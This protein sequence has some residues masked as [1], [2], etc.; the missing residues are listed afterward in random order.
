MYIS[1]NSK[2]I[3]SIIVALIWTT[4]ALYLAGPWIN[5][6]SQ[7]IGSFLAHFVIYGIAIFPGFMNAFLISSLLL[8]KRPK[9]KEHINY[10]PLTI[11]I[12]AYNEE[13]TICDTIHS[14]LL[15]EYTN[16]FKIIVLDDGSTDDT[17]RRVRREYSG[18]KKVVIYENIDNI[19]K[20]NLLNIGLSMVETDIFITIDSDSYLYHDSLKHLVG[21]Y[22]SDPTSAAIVGA[23]LVRN[24]RENVVTRL[25]E[26]D[27]F[28]GIAAIK[29]IQSLYQGTLVAQGAYS[30]YETDK[31]R[32]VDGW[33]DTV[34]EDI[35]LTWDLLERGYRI[36]YAE[37]ACLFTNAPNTWKQFFKQRSRWSRGIIE[38]FKNNW[39][40]LFRARKTTLFI[41]WNLLFVYMDLVY[42]FA[43]IPGIILAFFGIYSIVGPMTLLVL[44]LAMIVNF[45]MFF[46]SN[47]M[48]REQ[49]LKVRGNLLG[50][51]LYSLVYSVIL[52]PASTFGYIKELLFPNNKNWGTK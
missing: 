33:R 27:Y 2:Y 21:R 20:A 25:Q 35:V 46:R 18:N 37:N 28:H 26:W 9:I 48:F 7:Y 34:G 43:F 44:P 17:V 51:I 39:K 3:I 14:I 29:R 10:P 45:V 4:L 19:G 50:F 24:S 47:A 38:A 49:G 16:D 1:V 40:I 36:G 12:P 52:Q 11:L 5:D 13:D 6:L 41:W 31:V 23:V 42:T 8:D 32:L 15:Q 22:L 30:L